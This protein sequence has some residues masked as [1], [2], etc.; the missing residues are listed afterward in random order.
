MKLL[1]GAFVL[2][3]AL[4]IACS[5]ETTPPPAQPSN[6]TAPE[7]NLT[8]TTAATE[9]PVA[10]GTPAYVL[11][12]SA[13]P[14]IPPTAIH[15]SELHILRVTIAEIPTNL[16]DYDR[17]DWKHWTDEDGDCQDARNEVLN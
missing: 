17:Q 11:V 10:T 6:G 8:A 5:S 4:I 12:T 16:P 3:A 1:A 9:A 13:E 14:T 15:K 2:I 7:T